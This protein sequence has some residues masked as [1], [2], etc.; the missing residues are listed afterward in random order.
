MSYDCINKSQNLYRVRL[1]VFRDCTPPNLS[2]DINLDVTI[3]D[4][5]NNLIKELDMARGA[6]KYT[7]PE[8]NTHPCAINPPTS[9]IQY[10]EYRA[11]VILPPIA[12]G[13]T[14]SW[15]R[16]CRS[17]NIQN[18]SGAQNYGTTST[19]SIPSHDTICNS[20]PRFSG[21]IPPFLC[22]TDSLDF[23]L[24]AMD[25]DGDSLEYIMC[26]LYAGGGT[27]AGQFGC[28][29]T[30]TVPSPACPP[31]YVVVPFNG[32]NTVQNP[33]PVS[34]PI[35][36]DPVTGEMS[37]IADVSGIYAIGMCV[38]EYRD[39]KILSTLRLDYTFRVVSCLY[40]KADIITEQEDPHAL[41][42]G[43]TVN[44]NSESVNSGNF[45][46]NF[47]DTLNLGD[48]SNLENPSYTFPDE[49]LYEVKHV[50]RGI[51][52]ECNDTII[53]WFNVR[54]EVFPEYLWFGPTCFDRHEISFEALGHYPSDVIFSWDFDS[55]AST[56]TFDDRKP[57]KITWSKPGLHEVKFRVDYGVCYNEYIDT[58]DITDFNIQAGASQNQNVFRGEKVHLSAFG[59]AEYYWFANKPVEIS[60]R[61]TANTTA[62]MDHGVDTMIFY[63][64]I[65]NKDGC[66]KIDSVRVIV[67]DRSEDD[68]PINFFTPN[69]DG[70][71]D[72]M[73]LSDINP[74]ACSIRILNRWGQEVWNKDEYRNDWDGKDLGGNELPDGTYYYFLHCDEM[75][76]YQS[77]ITL[78]RDT[79]Q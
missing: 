15:Q 6:P 9:C 51:N 25:P 59:G 64:R 36:L 26:E 40:T 3:Y 69:G 35:T 47:G 17:A 21:L 62:R 34:S 11:N 79:H 13:Y 31:P 23:K 30:G 68:Q 70:L 75:I 4:S 45:Y 16:C 61:F 74:D 20:S 41:C 71:N 42:H 43:L 67:R 32:T 57:P 56:P 10:V 29:A 28:T 55:T 77:A 49:G 19:I 33:I 22:L 18:I 12:G 53:S 54:N 66:E 65:K 50:A 63:V 2:F 73:D 76:I 14:L 58:V 48:T 72:Y 24:N 7:P 1:T 8:L 46:W 5:L 60:S 39:N 27:T 78:L 52:P 37:G 44:F 38:N